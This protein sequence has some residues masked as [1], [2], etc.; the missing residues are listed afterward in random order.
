[1]AESHLKQLSTQRRTIIRKRRERDLA[2][3]YNQHRPDAT[4][5]PY[6]PTPA[7]SMLPQTHIPDFTYINHE[8]GDEHLLEEARRGVVWAHRL[9]RSEPPWKEEILRLEEVLDYKID[10]KHLERNRR[11]KAA[12]VQEEE[13]VHQP[14]SFTAS[15]VPGEKVRTE[16]GPRRYV[17]YLNR[18]VQ[19]LLA[20]NGLREVGAGDDEVTHPPELRERAHELR[21]EGL[22]IREI[23]ERLEDE[24]TRVPTPTLIRWLNPEFEARERRKAKKRKFSET[25]RCPRCKKKMS[26]LS[27]LCR[28][29]YQADQKFWTR[30]KVI[31][32]IQTWAIEKGRPPSYQ[33]WILSGPG[34]PA[35]WTITRGST[36]A[37][38]SF[39]AALVAAGFEP[40][41][42]RKKLTPMDRQE[43]AAMRRKSREEAIKRAL[44]KGSDDDAAGVRDDADLP[45]E[46]G[47]EA[48]GT[49]AGRGV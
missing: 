33:E 15:G 44:R 9:T 47:S 20:A 4:S 49:D 46:A 19:A 21:A 6:T 14:R 17:P 36:A 39:G 28:T 32:A 7:A 27:A 43:R 38:A 8:Y 2:G 29:C 48:G 26:N 34:H 25:R 10:K 45:D 22:L 5:G 30:E 24:G 12:G 42:R 13:T 1:M 11:R 35:I 18:P 16:G 31:E 40:R 41:K 37:F 3:G 23:A